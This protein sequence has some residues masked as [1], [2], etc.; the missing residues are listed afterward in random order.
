[1]YKNCEVTLMEIKKIN[2]DN[3]G[4]NDINAI[5]EDYAQKY[6]ELSDKILEAGIDIKYLDEL[7]RS[8]MSLHNKK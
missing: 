4:K 3:T 6:N 2:N 8:T 5:W 1:M 7:V